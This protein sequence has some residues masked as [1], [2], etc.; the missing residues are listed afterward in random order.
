VTALESSVF[1][2]HISSI[3][4]DV[5]PPPDSLNAPFQVIKIGSS[6]QPKLI[7]NIYFAEL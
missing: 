2:V 7:R 5:A 6:E 1:F 4:S 3:L